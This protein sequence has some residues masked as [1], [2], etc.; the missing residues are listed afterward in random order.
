MNSYEVLKDQERV[1]NHRLNYFSSLES[2]CI[3]VSLRGG[4]LMAVVK[5][6]VGKHIKV[7]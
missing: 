3:N 5:A 7:L 4:C 1:M 6:K 2:P